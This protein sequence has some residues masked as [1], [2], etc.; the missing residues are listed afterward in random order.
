MAPPAHYRECQEGRPA[1][2]VAAST[3]RPET[4]PGFHG[5]FRGAVGDHRW[6]SRRRFHRYGTQRRPIVDVVFCD[7]QQ[8]ANGY[9]ATNMTRLSIPRKTLALVAALCAMLICPIPAE[10]QREP[11]VQVADNLGTVLAGEEPC[12]L[13]YDKD[14]IKLFVEK[15]VT[16]DDMEFANYL[17]VSTWSYARDM[18]EMSESQKVAACK[19]IER[20]ALTYHFIKWI[21]PQA[22]QAIGK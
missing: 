20:V 3:P 10:A 16:N 13:A 8:T 11:S 19:Q 17:S 14:A 7:Y 4:R 18:K 9:K 2:V 12:G 5:W 1:G 21:S 15:H 6:W 22:T